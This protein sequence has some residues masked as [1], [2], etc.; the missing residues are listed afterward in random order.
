[1]SYCSMEQLPD[2]VFIDLNNLKELSLATTSIKIVTKYT[3][4]GLFELIR[5]NLSNTNLDYIDNDAF[6]WCEKLFHQKD[7]ELRIY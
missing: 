7:E 6:K 2:N 4:N 1:M 3:F 5:L